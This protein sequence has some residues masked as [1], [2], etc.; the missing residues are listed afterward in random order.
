MSWS[1]DIKTCT[2]NKYSSVDLKFRGLEPKLL[3]S[4][5]I[6]NLL[7]TMNFKGYDVFVYN[8][9]FILQSQEDGKKTPEES[10][11]SLGPRHPLQN[12]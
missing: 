7:Q 2:F 5:H 10:S 8:N 9:H 1:I 6:N 4:R 3:S 12:K 11:D